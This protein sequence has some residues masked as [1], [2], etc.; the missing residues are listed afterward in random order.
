MSPC[1]SGLHH[2]TLPVSDLDASAAWYGAVLGAVRVPALDHHDPGGGRFSVVLTVPG[3]HVPLQLR[4]APEA[5]GTAGGYDPL[6]WPSPTGPRWSSGRPTR[7]RGRGTRPRRRGPP[8]LRAGLP[9]PGRNPA[10]PVHRAGRRSGG[11][12]RRSGAIEVITDEQARTAGTPGPADCAAQRFARPVLTQQ[13]LP[14]QQT[15][16]N[17]ARH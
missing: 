10:A 17:H 12:R 15:R 2:V 7:R 14:A 3:L 1:L 8:G 13:P 4:L 6:T 16:G 5:A 9:R 11:R